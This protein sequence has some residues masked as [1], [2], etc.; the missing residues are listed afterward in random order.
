MVLIT[1]E[2]ICF[3]CKTEYALF[4]KKKD[5]LKA[6]GYRIHENSTISIVAEKRTIQAIEVE[7]E[8]KNN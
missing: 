6:K 5:E 7:D 1:I 3:D 8:S 2:K 4:L